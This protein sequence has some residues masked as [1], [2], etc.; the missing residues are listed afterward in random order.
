MNPNRPIT[1]RASL[2]ALPREAYILFLGTFLNKFGA[3]VLP[4]LAIYMTRQGYSVQEAG[5][6]MGA[7]GAGRLLAA[8]LGG[9]LADRLGRRPT[10]ILSMFSN[11]PTWLWWACGVLGLMS[12]A[13]ML[14]NLGGY[15][16]YNR[17]RYSLIKRILSGGVS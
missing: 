11:N 15:P 16:A 3:F 2:A 5:L 12:S 17:D 9:Y 13:L 4:F 7:Y 6:A 1:L 8:G 14:L 10:T